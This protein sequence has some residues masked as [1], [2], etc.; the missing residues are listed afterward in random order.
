MDEFMSTLSM[1]TKG[2]S[3]SLVG[4]A[5]ALSV[6][7]VCTARPSLLVSK[8]TRALRAKQAEIRLADMYSMHCDCE[9]QEKDGNEDGCP[10][11]AAAAKN[12]KIALDNAVDRQFAPPNMY[13]RTRNGYA[14]R[15]R[16]FL[17]PRLHLHAHRE[18]APMRV[19]LGKKTQQRAR[20]PLPDVPTLRVP[21]KFVSDVNPRVFY[22]AHLSNAPGMA[23]RKAK[24]QSL[25]ELGYKYDV[26]PLADETWD[27][28]SDKIE[29]QGGE[30]QGEEGEV[31]A[32]KSGGEVDDIVDS[33]WF[34]DWMDYADLI[35]SDGVLDEAKHVSAIPQE[36]QQ[37]LVLPYQEGEETD[38]ADWQ[39]AYDDD[40][41]VPVRTVVVVEEDN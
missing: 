1:K 2:M 33:P 29:E 25:D 34:A 3:L 18:I 10:C 13:Y 31:N 36:P 11:A 40:A 24:L 41:V 7:L 20:K 39:Y 37:A 35:L 23:E 21:T 30:Q 26:V 17:P 16:G 27:G 5:A 19:K 6:L 14:Y 32:A 4:L 28:K 15:L 22:Q 38:A 9:D 12:I 8:Q